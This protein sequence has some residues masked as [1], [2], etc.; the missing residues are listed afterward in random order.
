[1]SEETKIDLQSF[2]VPFSLD[3]GDECVA[4]ISQP[5]A[6]EMDAM[7]KTLGFLFSEFQKALNNGTSFAV[8][9]KDWEIMLDDFLIDD[10]RGEEQKKQLKAFFERRILQANIFNKSTGAAIEEKLPENILHDL[11]GGLLFFVSTL[12]YAPQALKM[13]ELKDFVTSLPLLE[14]KEH[15]KKSSTQ[16]KVEQEKTENTKLPLPRA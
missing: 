5:S 15:L 2:L 9:V 16:R 14:F 11:K 7:A 6:A 4:Y 12:R 13:K 3:N 10:K 8:I 1:M